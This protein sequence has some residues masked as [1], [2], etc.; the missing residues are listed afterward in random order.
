MCPQRSTVW[1][2]CQPPNT[3]STLSG[4]SM[5]SDANFRRSEC[6]PLPRSR[7]SLASRSALCHQVTARPRLMLA[8]RF[9]G[10]GSTKLSPFPGFASRASS[11]TATAS[12]VIGLTCS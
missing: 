12:P 4:R 10:A 1:A 7:S 3:H 5:R 2:S 9:G 6:Q 11:N 8:E